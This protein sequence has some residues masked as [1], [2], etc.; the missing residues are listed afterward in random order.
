MQDRVRELF[1]EMRTHEDE[2]DDIVVVDAG[3]GV[4]DVEKE[5]QRVVSARF[6]KEEA[7]NGPLRFIRPWS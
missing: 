4:E 3:S 7:G 5:I 6:Q 2:R 1:S